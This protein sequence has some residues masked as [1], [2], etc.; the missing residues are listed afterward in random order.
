M[1][2][3]WQRKIY[4]TL[5]KIYIK[6]FTFINML[7]SAPVH[8]LSQ[9]QKKNQEFTLSDKGKLILLHRI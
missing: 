2:K 4:I 6:M 9:T 1:W 8:L 5:R 3:P 7:M